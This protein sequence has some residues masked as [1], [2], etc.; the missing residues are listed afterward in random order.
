LLAC[1]FLAFFCPSFND[2]DAEKNKKQGADNP[3]ES[4]FKERAGQVDATDV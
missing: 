4:L 1:L 3:A 2:D